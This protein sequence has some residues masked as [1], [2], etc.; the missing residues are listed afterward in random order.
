MYACIHSR[1]Y[2][3]VRACMYLSAC[4]H[5]CIYLY[6]YMH[7]TSTHRLCFL[8]RRPSFCACMFVLRYVCNVLFCMYACVN[9]CTHSYVCTYATYLLTTLVFSSAE[10]RSLLSSSWIL[11]LRFSMSA[12]TR[13][14]SS[15]I[16]PYPASLDARTDFVS[17]K[18]SSASRQRSSADRECAF[19]DSSAFSISMTLQSSCFTL[20]ASAS[21]RRCPCDSSSAC[22]FWIS[23]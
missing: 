22:N 4:L 2:A 23:M 16:P 12:R 15:N 7:H 20:R 1:I 18:R 11:R 13:F 8:L 5:A 10:S 3:C 9:L 6:M 17:L 19:S 14:L 21:L